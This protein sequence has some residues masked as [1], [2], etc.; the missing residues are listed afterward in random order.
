[1]SH[2]QFKTQMRSSL[3]DR[4]VV[5]KL[6]TQVRTSL[7]QGLQNNRLGG[8]AKSGSPALGLE[9]RAVNALVADFLRSARLPY[10]LSVFVPE[11]GGGLNSSG[12]D[13]R[14]DIM[15]GLGLLGAQ[16]AG[17]GGKSLLED[18][19]CLVRLD[20]NKTVAT[21]EVQTEDAPS[22]AIDVE[23][24][25]RDLDEEFLRHAA[26][27]RTSPSRCV[28]ERMR[29]YQHEC[30]ERATAEVSAQ[31]ERLRETEISRLRSE[32]RAQY[33]AQLSNRLDELER[34]HAE[35]TVRQKKREQDAAERIS[36]QGRQLD[37]E[38]HAHRQRMLEDLDRCKERDSDS[39]R[40]KLANEHHIEQEMQRIR[41]MEHVIRVEHAQILQEQAAQFVEVPKTDSGTVMT[42]RRSEV[43]LPT[44]MARGA[45][46]QTETVEIDQLRGQNELLQQ[47]VATLTQTMEPTDDAHGQA[48]VAEELAMCQ[49][50]VSLLREQLAVSR[51][52]QAA[53]E[54]R[55]DSVERLA[56]AQ[57]TP[58]PET[59]PADRSE[60]L[61]T[62]TCELEEQ[63]LVNRGLT[64]KI[65]NLSGLLRQ[66][67]DTIAAEVEARASCASEVADALSAMESHDRSPPPRTDAWGDTAHTAVQV[68]LSQMMWGVQ[69]PSHWQ[70]EVR[71]P[72]NP[73][74]YLQPY[75]QQLQQL[76]QPQQ[77]GAVVP[78]SM[79]QV[80]CANCTIGL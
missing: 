24:R 20:H 41:A 10:A 59:N 29:K 6:K 70:S 54:Q 58:E 3:R 45:Q 12:S 21:S 63:Q 76:P 4:G 38:S 36:E 73:V 78:E 80:S 79:A 51:H 72:V 19:I 50:Q 42:P 5:D 53:S 15:T 49:Q 46:D 33:A 56:D 62:V 7:V 9:Q 37:A 28:E 17:S 64:R 44:N 69:P 47:Q 65:T 66:A 16:L 26:A 1:M 18:L 52:A 48:N 23:A 40:R 77:Q 55:V 43:T 61:E 22:G 8:M 14:Q 25:L 57:S 35:R 39:L 13:S 30:D 2:S 75:Q 67:N 68:P 60:E 74:A 11:S 31:V 32:E 27:E 34:E 71:Q